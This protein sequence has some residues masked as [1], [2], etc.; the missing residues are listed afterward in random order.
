[1]EETSL[2]AVFEERVSKQV[3]D[4]SEIIES[5]SIRLVD[6]ESKLS[7]LEKRTPDSLENPHEPSKERASKFLNESREKFDNI[8]SILKNK[9][10]EIKVDMNNEN[11]LEEMY[12]QTNENITNTEELIETEYI[13]TDSSEYLSA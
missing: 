3:Y 7:E 13:D 2:K 8:E 12:S 10:Q 5:V 4:L 1:M 6:L 9:K 11:G